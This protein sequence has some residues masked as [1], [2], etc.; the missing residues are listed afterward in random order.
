MTRNTRKKQGGFVLTSELLLIVTILVLGLIVG[1]AT[2]RNAVVAE[3]ED[4]A[5]AIGSVNQSFN[6][7]GIISAEPDSE[8]AGG[9]F[10]DA[11][12][13][14]GGAGSSGPGGDL[15]YFAELAASNEAGN[16][17]TP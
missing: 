8:T 2:V 15:V 13:F 7:T 12:D 16:N 3:M 9:V 5:E 17:V 11:P 4:Y 6:Y 1:M 10:V 14:D